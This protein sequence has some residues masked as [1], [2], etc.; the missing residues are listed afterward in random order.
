MIKFT[1]WA[2]TAALI[3]YPYLASAQDYGADRSGGPSGG[4]ELEYIGTDNKGSAF[5][6][7]DIDLMQR[8]L[9]AGAVSLGFDLGVDATFDLSKGD[10][11]YA[12]FGAIVVDPGFGEIA[13]GAPRSIGSV[14]I[15]RPVFAGNQSRDSDLETVFAPM[16]DS[17]AKSQQV[18]S[19]GARYESTSGAVRYG[20]SVQKLNTL[21]G[22]FLQ[23]GAEYSFGQ[24]AVEGVVEKRTNTD[25]LNLTVG[26]SGAAQQVDYALYLGHQDGAT[27]TTGVQAGLG[28]AVSD[29]LRVG[30]DFGLRQTPTDESTYYGASAEY[31][32][33]S[34][35][36]AQI[37][38]SDGNDTRVMWDASVGFDF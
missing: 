23:A 21:D 13:V 4:F 16:S 30:G 22:M 36:Y 31:S 5:L 11:R 9:S 12:F 1:G 33:D 34:G 19:Y 32:F 37:G 18:Q 24:G 14:L 3:A 35:I 8:G 7:G 25:G 26:V 15:D 10:D 20:A 17:L 38:V 29:S 28:Y 6:D 27:D 2:A